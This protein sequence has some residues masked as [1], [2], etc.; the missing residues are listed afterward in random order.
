MSV[1]KLVILRVS[2]GSVVVVV[3]VQ[4]G[5]VVAAHLDIG[6]AQVM[7]EG[8]TVLVVVPLVAAVCLLPVAVATVDLLI[9]DEMKLPMLTEM[10]SGNDTE[11]GAE[12]MK[13]YFQMHCRTFGIVFLLSLN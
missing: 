8:V 7:V 1:G 3:V 10:V 9:V 13:Y 2:A 12:A 11:A 6:E 4:E 5:A